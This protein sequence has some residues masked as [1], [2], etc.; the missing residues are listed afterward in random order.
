[1]ISMEVSVAYIP[2]TILK[3]SENGNAALFLSFTAYPRASKKISPLMTK[4]RP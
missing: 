4:V 2:P 1:M 3:K